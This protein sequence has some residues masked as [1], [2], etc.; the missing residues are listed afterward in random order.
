MQRKES[1][2]KDKK[3]KKE[4]KEKKKKHDKKKKKETSSDDESSS[5]EKDAVKG[6][7]EAAAVPVAPIKLQAPKVEMAS[8]LELDSTPPVAVSQSVNLMDMISGPSPLMDPNQNSQR[9]TNQ[10]MANFLTQNIPPTQ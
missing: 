8:L 3:E 7:K 9:Q 1:E 10:E 2:K 5:E 6:V 4:K